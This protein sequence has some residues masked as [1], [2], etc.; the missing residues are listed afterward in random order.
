MGLA[1]PVDRVVKVVPVLIRSGRYP[2]PWLGIEELG[3]EL[4]PS[5]ARALGLP[6]DKGLLVARLYNG[7]PADQAGIRSAQRQVVLG[8]RRYLLG[9]DIISAI[10]GH[11]LAKW[12]DLSEYLQE[13][14]EVGQVITLTVYRDGS[15]L[16]IQARLEDTPGALG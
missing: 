5:L 4:S 1:I 9:G 11:P 3:Y 6:I 10:D 15:Q 2:H 13:R 8:N 7:S 14:T 16:S 12:T